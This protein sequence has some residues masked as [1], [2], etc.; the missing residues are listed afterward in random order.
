MSARPDLAGAAL[1]V[2]PVRLAWGEVGARSDVVLSAVDAARAASFAAGRREEFVTGRALVRGLL[3]AMALDAAVTSASCPRCGRP[4]GGVLVANGAGPEDAQHA[5]AVASV[6]H[7][8]GLVVA[9]VASGRVRRVG[10]DLEPAPAE[11][12]RLADLAALIGGPPEDALRRWTLIEAVLK[13]DGR[14]LQVDPAE[15]RLKGGGRGATARVGGVRYR[16]AEI[17]APQGWIAS[18]AWA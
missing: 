17:P 4:H 13:A 8:G 18:L 2:G 12:D 3:S 7:A 10:V 6:A 15:V 1:R 11:E 5:G 16:L 9:A 14:G